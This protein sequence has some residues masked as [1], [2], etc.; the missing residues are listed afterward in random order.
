M[1]VLNQVTVLDKYDPSTSIQDVFP[2]PNGGG[3]YYLSQSGNSVVVELQYGT[4]EVGTGNWSDEQTLGSG[5]YGT[6]P[7]NASGIRFRNAVAGKPCVVTAVLV[8]VDQPVLGVA[9]LGT[10]NVVTAPS[11]NFQH[12]TLAVATEPTLDFEDS[13]SLIW[14]PVDDP[15]NTRVKVTAA[16]QHLSGDYTVGQVT[17]AAPLASPTF[18]GTPA[19]P[20]PA[21]AD[22]STTIAT[23]AFVKNQ[24]YVTAATAPVTSVDGRTGAVTGLADLTSGSAQVFAGNVSTG[25]SAISAGMAAGAVINQAG[26]A[27]LSA[28]AGSVLLVTVPGDTAG[29]YRFQI[30]INGVHS[31]GTGAAA[32]DLV[33]QRAAKGSD[34]GFDFSSGS[35]VGWAQ[36]SGALYPG[37]AATFT[38][39]GGVTWTPDYALGNFQAANINVAGATTLTITTPSNEPPSGTTGILWML[40]ENTA[41]SGG[42]TLTWS[43]AFLNAFSNIPKPTV[44]NFGTSIFLLF[45]FNSVT[46]GWKCVGQF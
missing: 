26:Q 21:T 37:A 24:N 39:G 20:T 42:T 8:P 5:A 10:V 28:T 23:T 33:Q 9:N 40:I 45:V 41:G 12:N 44:V 2:V 1:P 27:G 46:L 22:N 16:V 35:G 25:A 30:N 43:G 31:W 34:I 19:A 3:W 6:I 4:H 15:V 14:S 29:D 17:G 7:P 36:F 13:T 38:T 32:A 18:T 11:L